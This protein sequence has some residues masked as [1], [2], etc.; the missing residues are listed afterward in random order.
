VSGRKIVSAAG[1]SEEKA[2]P[3]PNTPGEPVLRCIQIRKTYSGEGMF[4]LGPGSDGLTLDV[5]R[6][7]L[8]ALVGP[9]GCGKTTTLGIIGGFIRPDAGTVIIDGTDMTRRPPY[10]RPTNTVFQSY[11]LFPH[12]SVGANVSF[13]LA[14]EHMPRRA[15]RARV[16]EVLDLVGLTGFERRRVSELSGGQQQRAAIARAL[17]KRPALLLL[18]EPMGSLDAQLRKQMQNELVR[19][20]TTTQTAFVHVTHDQ[21]EACAIADRMG[22]MKD[23][24]LVQVGAPMTLYRQPATSYVAAFLDVG[25]VIR[26]ST[27]RHGDLLE[28]ASDDIAVR[29]PAASTAIAGPVAA[30]IPADKVRIRQGDRVEGHVQAS[31]V[32]NRV[33]FT[34]L[35]VVVFVRV[36]AALEMRALLSGD[37]VS[38]FGATLHQETRVTLAWDPK[39][40]LFVSDRPGSVAQAEDGDA[41]THGTPGRAVGR[42]PDRASKRSGA[43]DR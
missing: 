42:R 22:V 3:D 33:T 8:F 35:N 14:M 41:L 24:H 10:A 9:S 13:G 6:G 36:G 37:Q 2:V 26:G 38:A 5:A 29:A 34:G 19:L 17:V 25:T 27:A 12:M 32:I 15:R 30:V 1:R 18:D 21:E 4:T 16:A 20:K 11:A 31:G 43:S 39:D 7:E 23:G 40:V 28:I